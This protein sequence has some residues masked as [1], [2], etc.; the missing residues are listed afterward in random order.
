M[1]NKRNTASVKASLCM[2]AV[3]L[4]RAVLL[5][6]LRVI[7]PFFSAS[8]QVCAAADSPA[9]FTHH[10]PRFVPLPIPQHVAP[11]SVSA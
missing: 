3:F 8:S 4:P 1:R 2:I 7:V 11:S 10:G 9:L 5:F 6:L